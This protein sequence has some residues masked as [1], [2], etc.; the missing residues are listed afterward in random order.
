MRAA[1]HRVQQH[2]Q[3][4]PHDQR[5]VVVVVVVAV[6]AVAVGRELP[7]PH[8]LQRGRRWGRLH[9][10]QHAL[11][12]AAARVRQQAVGDEHAQHW[13]LQAAC[14]KFKGEPFIQVFP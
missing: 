14:S 12:Q 6:G 9:G 1:P 3:P 13:R 4:P 11:P 5:P 7:Q 10:L 2:A 8:R